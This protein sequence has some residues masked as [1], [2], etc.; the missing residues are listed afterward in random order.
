MAK[1]SDPS[2]TSTAPTASSTP[3]ARLP[4]QIWVL[5]VAAF[6]IALGYGLVAPALPTFARS[7][8][9]GV[10]AASF[11][12][13]SFAVFRL[14]FAPISGRLVNSFGELRVY[15]IGLLIV[16]LSTGACAFAQAYWQLL[17]FRSLGGIGSTMFTVSSISLLVRL[18]PPALRGR[19]SGLW[20]TGFL[21]GNIAGP[22]VGGG[23]VAFS[24][25]APFLVYAVVL[26]VAA[27]I[28]G[29]LL[30][31]SRS[32]AMPEIDDRVV[33]PLRT[34]LAQPHLP[35]SADVQLRQRLDRLRRAGG[36]DAAVRR[37]GA[38]GAAELGRHR[39]CGVRRVATR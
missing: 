8:D 31:G 23:L 9:V 15:L 29:L 14:S 28:T 12:I 30:R 33:V 5:V 37:R 20:A 26:V 2:P 17:L 16:A 4:V 18:A 34:A 36:V 22:V 3:G 24:L 11:V 7:F 35:R 19:A 39:P 1:D 27:A 10:T 38:A 13:S 6:V 32:V 21:L 25:R